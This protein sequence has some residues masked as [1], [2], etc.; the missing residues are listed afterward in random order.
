[1]GGTICAGVRFADDPSGS[2][3]RALQALVAG[4][5]DAMTLDLGDDRFKLRARFVVIDRLPVARQPVGGHH[6]HSASGGEPVGRQLDVATNLEC[7]RD[8]CLVR[9]LVRAEPY[10]A[11]RAEDLA[12]AELGL[13][14]R[15]ATPPSAHGPAARG[16]PCWR[17]S[18]SW[19]C[20]REDRRRTQSPKG[21]GPDRAGWP[22]PKPPLVHGVGRATLS[23]SGAAPPV[24]MPRAAAVHDS[25]RLGIVVS[26]AAEQRVW[27][28]R[29]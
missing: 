11:V 12:P 27:T 3:R 19:S 6:V 29:R 13:E 24:A 22:A 15:Q 18:T 8:R 28:C 7:R 25:R 1:L 4:H 5:L 21:H 2:P 23:P 26:M 9:R 10:L 16:P 20:R 17:S 14:F